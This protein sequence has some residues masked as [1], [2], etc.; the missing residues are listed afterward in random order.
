MQLLG[1]PLVLYFTLTDLGLFETLDFID[2]RVISFKAFVLTVLV[3]LVIAAFRSIFQ[4]RIEIG[5][6][7]VLADNHIIL[8]NPVSVFTCKVTPIMN[9]KEMHI[10]V[11]FAFSGS[12]VYFESVCDNMLYT[13]EI[14]VQ[15][16]AMIKG[17]NFRGGNKCGARIGMNKRVRLYVEAPLN[18]SPATLRVFVT[19]WGQ[20]AI[21]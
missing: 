15:L 8:H 21:R 1:F 18:A 19:S 9:N 14:G 4:A 3:F 20:D 11:P 17:S 2:E 13:V 6:K 12:F 10:E 7:G 5:E 16:S